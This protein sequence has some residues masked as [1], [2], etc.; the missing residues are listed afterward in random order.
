VSAIRRRR[1]VPLVALLAFVVV[2]AGAGLALRSASSGYSSETAD[3]TGAAPTAAVDGAGAAPTTE[4]APYTI[5]P[6]PTQVATD[7]PRPSDAGLDVV[8]T[9]AVF[10]STTG[11]VQANGYVA[12]TIEEG[13]TCTLTLTKGGQQVTATSTS[14]ADA[15]TTSCGLVETAPGLGAGTWEAVLS[16]KGTDSAAV[17]VTVP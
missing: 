15:T 4:T 1:W 16:Y 9:S 14:L 12:G 11:T 2:A 10:D 6:E 7:P 17:E 5:K 13:G 8:L 3:A